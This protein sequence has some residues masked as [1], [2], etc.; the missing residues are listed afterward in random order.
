MFITK[1]RLEQIIRDEKNKEADRIYSEERVQSQFREN[2]SRIW[3]LKEEVCVLNK[4]VA[5]LK[6]KVF[7]I[8]ENEKKPCS[9]KNEAIRENY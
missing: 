6:A 1:K 5:D 4:E 9:F 3:E 7:G 8:P 2:N